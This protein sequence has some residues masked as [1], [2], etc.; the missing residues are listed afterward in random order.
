LRSHGPRFD[1][2]ELVANVV[3]LSLREQTL[4]AH[5]RQVAEGRVVEAGGIHHAAAGELV[6]DFV[7]KANLGS[8]MGA[9]DIALPLAWLHGSVM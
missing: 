7:D 9:I 1:Q 3:D 6:E 4:W 8:G 2:V 5:G